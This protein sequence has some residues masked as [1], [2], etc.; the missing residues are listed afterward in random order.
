MFSWTLKTK[1]IL[2]SVIVLLMLAV[3]FAITGQAN[4]MGEYNAA[5]SVAVGADAPVLSGQP[6]QRSCVA[7]IGC[8]EL[9]LT[10]CL[11]RHQKTSDNANLSLDEARCYMLT[12][13]NRDRASL[14]LQPVQLDATGTVAAQ[15][16]S[17]EMAQRGY[18]SHWDLQGRKP[19][20]RYGE[21][22]GEGAVFE[23]VYT[24]HNNPY[25]GFYN[26]LAS[27][28]VFP[29]AE[30]E[31]AE[32]WFFNQT[33]PSDGHRRNILDVHHNL[34]GLGISL[35]VDKRF[36]SRITVA[37]E[38]VNQPGTFRELPSELTVGHASR[39][40]G[41]LAKGLSLHAVQICWEN[42]PQP[43]SLAE[44]KKTGYYSIPQNS[45]VSYFPFPTHAAPPINVN[46]TEQGQEFSLVVNP[47]VK[48]QKGLYYII[49]WVRDPKSDTPFIA[50]T[51]TV[52]FD[53]E[54][55]MV[56]L[57]NAD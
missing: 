53:P 32:A 4:A 14:G 57:A 40:S 30:I 43:M 45:V 5:S 44:L 52:P 39:L 7:A 47:Q 23:N 16:H 29:K 56:H 12:L 54:S 46:V 3:G 22:G 27:Q 1:Q 21:S 10:G 36:G 48:W 41:C 11:E 15:M 20:Q 8:S 34:V 35:S 31:R 50:A 51:R 55:Q 37:Q 19:D 18:I 2:F 6:M 33:P 38:F 49:V 25:L 26:D 13:I 28:Q 24:N 9:S 17:D 42:M